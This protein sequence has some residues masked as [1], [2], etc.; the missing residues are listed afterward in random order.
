VPIFLY[1][2]AFQCTVDQDGCMRKVQA[3]II[4]EM[5]VKQGNAPISAT[6]LFLLLRASAAHNST[7]RNDDF[8]M[9]S[10]RPFNAE[11]AGPKYPNI[12]K[13]VKKSGKYQRKVWVSSCWYFYF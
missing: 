2:F 11:Q 1:T 6:V 5:P 9:Q 10:P 4:Q 7:S 8:Q 12:I 3:E 13:E